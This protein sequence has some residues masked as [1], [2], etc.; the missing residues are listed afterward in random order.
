MADDESLDRDLIVVSYGRRYAEDLHSVPIGGQANAAEYQTS[1]IW[2]CYI[3]HHF[4]RGIYV[5]TGNRV[6]LF[7]VDTVEHEF[8]FSA[9]IPDSDMR[10]VLFFL[11]HSICLSS[12]IIVRS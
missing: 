11:V 7:A 5:A 3:P 12:I 10:R 1:H 6:L 9:L 4:S 8:S 2:N